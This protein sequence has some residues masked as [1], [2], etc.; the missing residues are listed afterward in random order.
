[1]TVGEEGTPPS[2]PTLSIDLEVT[3]SGDRM[4]DV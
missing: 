1:M 3:D 2:H 4:D